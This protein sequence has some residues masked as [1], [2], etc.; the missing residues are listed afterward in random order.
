MRKQILGLAIVCG[1]VTLAVI[2]GQRMSTDAMAVVIGVVFGVAASIPT[3]LLIIA[4]TQRP[5]HDYRSLGPDPRPNPQQP[6]IYLVNPGALPTAQR[7]QPQLPEPA[8]IA[9]PQQP[10]RYTIVGDDDYDDD[11]ITL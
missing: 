7:P 4:V 5:H 11:Q 1:M 8:S 2:I 9:M 6:N 10:R 3:S